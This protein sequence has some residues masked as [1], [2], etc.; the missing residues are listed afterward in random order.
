MPAYRIY[1]MDQD[2]H[3]TEADCL[4]ADT[5]EVVR[6]GAGAHIGTASAVEVWHGSRLIVR[7]TP[8]EL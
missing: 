2:N 5:D 6:N 3:I 4:I 1:W 8:N 7:V